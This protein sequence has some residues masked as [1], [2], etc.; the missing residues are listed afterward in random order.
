MLGSTMELDPSYF[1]VIQYKSK[2]LCFYVSFT[3]VGVLEP[4]YLLRKKEQT[5]FDIFS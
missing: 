4:E 5:N 3:A 2:V 1:M